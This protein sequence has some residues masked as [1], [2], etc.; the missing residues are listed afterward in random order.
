ML[1]VAVVVGATALLLLLRLIGA[2]KKR[3]VATCELVVAGKVGSGS[4]GKEITPMASPSNTRYLDRRPSYQQFVPERATKVSGTVTL[5]QFRGNTAIDFKV[6]GLDPGEHGFHIHSTADSSDGRDLGN[7]TADSTGTAKGVI[8][9]SLIKLSGAN[10][11]VGRFI[12]V[13]HGKVS[14]SKGLGARIACGPIKLA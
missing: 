13:H 11:A 5:T 10:S 3:V 7:I 14:N 2:F 9:S 4:P 1:A 12:V 8:H 6:V